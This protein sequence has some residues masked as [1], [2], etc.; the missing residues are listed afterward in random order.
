[1]K[2]HRERNWR[3]MLKMRWGG[4]G[5]SVLMKAGVVLLKPKVVVDRGLV[6]GEQ[7]NSLRFGKELVALLKRRGKDE[8]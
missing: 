2:R 5:R 1:M 7:S 4:L 8:L 6:R 3:R